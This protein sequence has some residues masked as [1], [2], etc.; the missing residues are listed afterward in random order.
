MPH[1]ET[2][3]KACRFL[4]ILSL[5]SMTSVLSVRLSPPVQGCAA[6]PPPGAR[7]GIASEEALIVWDAATQ[8]EHF[9]RRASFV[10]EAPQFGFL[11]P[12]PSP[13]RLAET[14][15]AIF[16]TLSATYRPHIVPHPR[17]GLKLVSLFF[18]PIFA[19]AKGR[20]TAIAAASLERVS[21][22]DSEQVAGYDAVV[23]RADDAG[24]L[25]QMRGR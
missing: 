13:P 5:F 9:I 21:V 20:A 4:L 18:T 15:N 8:T 25:T 1:K 6:A 11:V 24:A 10:G 7:V 19:G 23:L 17:T 12:T 3:M 2:A 22:L 14:D 16:R